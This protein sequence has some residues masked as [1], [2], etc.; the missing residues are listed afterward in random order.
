MHMRFRLNSS[1]RARL[2]QLVVVALLPAFGL[3]VYHSGEQRKKALVDAE[4]E[5]LRLARVVAANE[6]RLIDSSGHLLIALAQ[7]PA[8][9]NGDAEAC[10]A[11]FARLLREYPPYANLGVA[12]LDG[13]VICS[14]R[15]LPN[16]ANIGDRW[17]FL[18]AIQ[19]RQLAIGNYQVGH[20]SGKAT[21][22]L[23]YP[24]YGHDE[25]LTGVAFLAL[26]LAWVSQTARIVGLPRGSVVTLYDRGGTILSRYPEGEG[27]VGNS[28][29]DAE[30]V[31]SVRAKGEGVTEATDIDGIRRLYGFSSIGGTSREGEIFLHIGIPKDVALADADWFLKR[32]LSALLLVGVLALLVAWHLGDALLVRQLKSLAKTT[33]RIGAGD[34]SARTGLARRKNEIDRFAA[35]LDTMA[36]LLE[37]RHNEAQAAKDR[38]QRRLE[39][40]SALSEIDMAIRS[41]LDLPAVLKVLLEKVDLVLSGA[42]T[43]ILL[44][45]RESGE[46]TPVA[47]R[48]LDE[49]AWRAENPRTVQGFAQT[50][51]ENRIPL[52]IAN[53]QTDPRG[54]DHH[55][56]K[57]FGLVSYLGVPLIAAGELLGLIAFYT[58]EAHSF[59]DDEIDFLTALSGLS[60]DAIYN[61]RLFEETCRRETEAL[62]LHAL[63]AAASQSL[64]LNIILKEAIGKISEIFHFDATR[65]FLFNHERTEL[66]IR[67][68]D[69]VREETPVAA[70][71]RQR[72]ESILGRVAE[73]TE[74]MIFEDIAT[75]RR[76]QELSATKI[77]EKAGN[78]FLA[79]FPIRTKLKSWGVAVFAG[80]VPRKLSADEI[81]LL[82]SMSHQIGIAVENATLF[83]Q[84]A[85]RAKELAALYSFAGLASQ[86]LDINILLRK[87]TSKILEIFQFDAA[88]VFLRQGQTDDIEL[89]A[90][91]GFPPDFMP[92]SRYR[93][94]EGRV[95]RAIESGEPMFIEDMEVDEEYQRTAHTKLM[96]KQGFRSSLLIPI[97][98]GG[99]NLGIMNFLCRK[100]YHFSE[101]DI[102]VI[103]AVAYHLG[104]AAGNANLYS[105]VRQKT[106]ELEKANKAKDEF[107]GVISHELR[108]PLNVI[109][110][111]ADVLRRKMFGEVNAEQES[112]LNKITTQ[113]MDLLH[114]IN[115]VLQ[116]STIEAKTTKVARA[117]VDLC[118]LLSELS[119]SYRFA[120]GGTVDISWEF[121]TDLPVIRTD[122]EKLRG[123]L[124]NLINNA[125]K[126]TERGT[127]VV[128]ARRVVEKNAVEFRIEDTGIGIPADKIETIFGMFQQ[129][130]SSVTRGYGGVG[131][132]LYT[133]QNFTELLGGRVAVASEV[134][135]GTRSEEHTSELQSLRHLV[136]RLLLE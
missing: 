81:R 96:L 15:P 120:S 48:N 91:I 87:T 72:G 122:E 117:D 36:E 108:T 32:N 128:S 55:F 68:A 103:H 93:V 58:K 52:T 35:S 97:K 112:A 29:Q 109:K 100:P 46:L 104:I 85:A 90:H 92:A 115:D 45:N 135:K 119:D 6:Q 8:V 16:A 113:S 89:V 131:L 86:S 21:L 40:L 71:R 59:D 124:Q 60:A 34:F 18:E 83:E 41:T 10:S 133:V 74:A 80:R 121:S 73:S 66:E 129:V 1:L 56:M 12:S 126:F 130:D 65:I 107:L 77:S 110:G 22:N 23:G 33:A 78:R 64:D 136:C 88:R 94:G 132:G 102:H 53:V 134:G 37:R 69:D 127:V 116:V 67:A 31:K 43:T 105:Q 63:T 57:K 76:Y 7:L 75:D 5:A 27:F 26:D 50:V 24:V 51:L 47:C 14:A 54:T 114:M 4:N 84:T 3:I 49:H 125:L 79:M 28:F 44:L 9:R 17:Y 118:A 19:H 38:A 111:Y 95:G 106:V 39:R 99:I 82:T 61:S 62:A 25:Q 2:F 98:V 101:S 11:L 42:V 20:I 123:M 13:S 30:I 70:M